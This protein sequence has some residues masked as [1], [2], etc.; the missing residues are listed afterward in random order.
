MLDDVNDSEQNAHKLGKLLEMFN[1]VSSYVSQIILSEMIWLNF[2]RILFYLKW[3][4]MKHVLAFL[5]VTCIQYSLL[6][7]CIQYKITKGV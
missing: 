3:S 2:L 4:Q 7:N 1:V 6:F 5:I